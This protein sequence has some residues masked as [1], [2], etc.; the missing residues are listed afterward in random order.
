M[1]P[2]EVFAW[3][4]GGSIAVEIVTLFNALHQR[5]QL[6][7]RYHSLAFWVVRLLVAVV[8]GGLALAYEIQTPIL[9]INVGAATPLIIQALARGA[10]SPV[11]QVG[12]S[13]MSKSK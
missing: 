3:G 10:Q 2:L 12:D 4:F 8:A 11:A 5:P 6:P 1:S 9:A 7:A 13:D